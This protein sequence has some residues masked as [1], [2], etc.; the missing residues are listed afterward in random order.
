MPDTWYTG[1]AAD[2]APQHR[3][4]L[5][6]HFINT[7][8]GGVR[9]NGAVEIK[10]AKHPAGDTRDQWTKDDT[11]TTVVLL[12]QGRFRVELDTGTAR[13]ERQGDY[14]MWGPGIDHSWHAEQDSIVLVIR[15]P[16]LTAGGS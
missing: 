13:L 15:W 4:W 3:G 5:V 10:W 14:V 16:S 12:I 2:D 9:S 11:R 7:D 6:G 8:T 1:N